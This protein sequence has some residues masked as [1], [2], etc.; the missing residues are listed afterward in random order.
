MNPAKR[1]SR[2]R[3]E[4][5]IPVASPVP[6]IVVAVEST[7]GAVVTLT[8][9]PQGVA[10]LVLRERGGVFVFANTRDVPQRQRFTL[11]HELGHVALGHSSHVDTA[12]ALR[13][14]GDPQE[15]EANHF[16]AEFLMPR[17]ALL[18][19]WP[20]GKAPEEPGTAIEVMRLALRFGMSYRAATFRLHNEKF[21]TAA[22]RD[23]LLTMD[24]PAAKATLRA[25]A[26]AV[27]PDDTV[28]QTAAGSG[29]R[30][31]HQV[32]E[33]IGRLGSSGIFPP[34]ALAAHFD[35]DRD[36]V[37]AALEGGDR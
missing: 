24:T 27:G 17:A 6:D 28:A 23:V 29:V 31:P 35:I 13:D 36:L 26:D 18:E 1:A 9:L 32:T 5:G 20:G 25:K 19:V 22:Q 8:R 4:A 34:D 3:A 33:G 11:A 2:L 15:S 37:D 14:F 7:V 21:V 10:G 30:L 16:A 12:E